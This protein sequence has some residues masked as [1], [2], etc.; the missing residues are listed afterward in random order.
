MDQD[1]A[2]EALH[3]ESGDAYSVTYE[4]GAYVARGQDGRVITGTTP[5]QLARDL[6]RRRP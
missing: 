2:I 5:D 6:G 3:L 1:R 4:S